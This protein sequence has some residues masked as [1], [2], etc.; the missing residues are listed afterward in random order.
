MKVTKETKASVRDL[1][2]H[3]DL[4]EFVGSFPAND[5]SIKVPAH[6]TMMLRLTMH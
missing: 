2:K 5:T 3:E 1:W 4:G 6:G